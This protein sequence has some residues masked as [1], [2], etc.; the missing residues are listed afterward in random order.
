MRKGAAQPNINAQ[1]YSSFDIPLP[2]LEEQQKFVSQIT[3]IEN[4]N[5][6]VRKR[7]FKY[8]AT[9]RSG[10]EKVFVNQVDF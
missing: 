9:K 7:N 6:R 2:T 3:E 1:Q 8:P 5:R 4:K 10:F